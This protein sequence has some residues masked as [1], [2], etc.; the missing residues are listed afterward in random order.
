M[1]IVSTQDLNE[2]P[3][4]FPM[5]TIAV[6]MAHQARVL[7]RIFWL[8]ENFRV[9]IDGGRGVCGRRPV[10]SRGVW[11]MAPQKMFKVLSLLRVIL[12]HFK[13]VLRS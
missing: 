2:L 10:F 5:A 7:F 12:R 11:G 3:V 8:G 1:I 9:E 13:T 4:P 6:C